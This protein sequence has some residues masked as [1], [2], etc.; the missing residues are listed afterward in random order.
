MYLQE[1][2]TPVAYL[3]IWKQ[4]AIVFIGSSTIGKKEHINQKVKFFQFKFRMIFL[5]VSFI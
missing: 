3:E 4:S 2:N 5:I 1:I